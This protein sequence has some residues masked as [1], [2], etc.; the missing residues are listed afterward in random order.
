MRFSPFLAL[1]FAFLAPY[2]S[3][4]AQTS[5]TQVSVANAKFTLH[6]ASEDSAGLTEWLS[7][8][9][10]AVEQFFGRPFPRKFD[11]YVFPNRAALDKQ[12]QQD[13]GDSTFQSSCWMVASGVGHRLDILSPRAWAAEACD[14][15][16]S[17]TSAL[18]RLLQHELVHVYH[19][20]HNAKPDFAEMDELGWWIEG[21][22][23]YAS[24]QLD[25]ARLA[26]VRDLLGKNAAPNVLK[27]FWSGK[28]K[29]GLAGSMAAWIDKSSGRAV[30]F[31]LLS[32]ADTSQVLKTLQTDETALLEAWGKYWA[33]NH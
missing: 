27:K 15:N 4:F 3:F 18:R 16:A 2:N 24:G 12:W 17:D 1:F 13:W 5:P 19:G 26:G 14:H 10:Q 23:V 31:N 25:E 6:C 11:V 7:E 22:A 21:I 29:Y 20:Q 8:G 33:E 32:C 28:N 9:V 30:V